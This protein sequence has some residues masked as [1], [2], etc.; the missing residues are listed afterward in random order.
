MAFLYG[1][2]ASVAPEHPERISSFIS[3]SYRYVPL[4]SGSEFLPSRS[5]QASGVFMDSLP[6]A[7]DCA[8]SGCSDAHSEYAQQCVGR[9]GCAT[10]GCKGLPEAVHTTPQLAY[11]STDCTIQGEAC[12][13]WL[14]FHNCHPSLR[15]DMDTYCK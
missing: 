9:C 3:S 2:Q 11:S 15:G 1:P 4:M 5:S 14:S 7:G 6:Q 13:N 8:L 10:P 12:Q